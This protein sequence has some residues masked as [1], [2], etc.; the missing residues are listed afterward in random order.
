[1][2]YLFLLFSSASIIRTEGRGYLLQNKNNMNKTT[3]GV[4]VLVLAVLALAYV[5]IS[6]K[7]EKVPNENSNAEP[8]TSLYE[9]KD[10]GFSFEYPERLDLKE[11][12]PDFIS[13]GKESGE[14]FQSEVDVQ[15]VKSHEGSPAEFDE[16]V[17]GEARNSCAADGVNESIECTDVEQEQPFETAS[18]LT[19]KVFYLKEVHKNLESGEEKI[20]GKGPFFVFNI[21]A[22][23]PESNFSALVIR[24]PMAIDKADSSLIRSVAESVKVNKVE[25]R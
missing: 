9:S 17:Y 18:G 21:S 12:Q 6:K 16:F 13:L 3:V 14:S 1:M 25:T 11:Y 8:K 24:T 5:F 23:D 10:H 15:V 2:H 7:E 20:G 4:V 22:N 19:G